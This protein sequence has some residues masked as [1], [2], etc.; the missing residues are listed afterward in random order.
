M[1]RE[2]RLARELLSGGD[3]RSV[4]LAS[5]NISAVDNFVSR[6]MDGGCLMRRVLIIAFLTLAV[7]A[8]AIGTL[9]YSI[10]SFQPTRHPQP[11]TGILLRPDGAEP[12]ILPPRRAA[13]RYLLRCRS[14]QPPC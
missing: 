10:Q 11:P 13:I 2:L 1:V 7:V 8:L 14:P 4:R 5:R 12:A 6:P 9:A 3:L